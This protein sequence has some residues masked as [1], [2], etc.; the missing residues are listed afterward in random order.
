MNS[1]I[2]TDPEDL[3]PARKGKEPEEDTNQPLGYLGWSAGHHHCAGMKIANLALKL[4]LL[5]L[6]VG[7]HYDLVTCGPNGQQTNIT[8]KLNRKYIQKACPL[9][10]PLYLKFKRARD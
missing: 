5:T 4:V 7:Y 6:V 10:D 8:P 3:A 1:E 2:Y 9:G